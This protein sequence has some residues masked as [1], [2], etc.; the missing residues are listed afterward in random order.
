MFPRLVAVS[1]VAAAVMRTFVLATMLASA[2][3]FA[4]APMIQIAMRPPPQTPP[5][6][7]Q[8]VMMDHPLLYYVDFPGFPSQASKNREIR[9]VCLEPPLVTPHARPLP[10]PLRP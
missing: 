1:T 7:M 4:P 3:S 10:G 8:P 9:K 5:R 6:V 2:S